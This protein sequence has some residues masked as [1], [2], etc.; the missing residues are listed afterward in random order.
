MLWDAVRCCG[1]SDAC[2][3]LW[4]VGCCGLWNDVG[5][6][7]PW[8]IGYCGMLWD[9]LGCGVPHKA[10]E[11]GHCDA[12]LDPDVA[13]GTTEGADVAVSR[14][15]HSA[16]G[17]LLLVPRP[18]AT[19]QAKGASEPRAAPCQ[20]CQHSAGRGSGG[21]VLIKCCNTLGIAQG[22]GRARPAAS[23][24]PV[25]PTGP[26]M[27]QLRPLDGT[28]AGKGI[29]GPPAACSGAQRGGGECEWGLQ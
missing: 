15:A 29:P 21:T 19:S 23:Q 6:E 3:M 2:G 7:M 12:G 9:A 16:V 27:A 28:T 8:A 4:S 22:S 10:V 24:V 5:C 11:R 26:Q 18:G 14:Q 17:M 25:S 20:P 1:I 13:L